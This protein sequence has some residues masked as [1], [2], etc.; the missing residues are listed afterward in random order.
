MSEAD[1]KAGDWRKGRAARTILDAGAIT[2]IV[3]VFELAADRWLSQTAIGMDWHYPLVFLAIMTYLLVRVFVF[4]SGDREIRR[5]YD[6]LARRR[7]LDALTR[8]PNRQ[9]MEHELEHMASMAKRMKCMLAVIILDVERLHEI[10]MAVGMSAGDETLLAVAERLKTSI[11]ESDALARIAGD[12]FAIAT[13]SCESPD[14]LVLFLNKLAQLFDKPLRIQSL[15]LDVEVRFGSILFPSQC[16]DPKA[17]LRKAYEALYHARENGERFG[18]YDSAFTEFGRWRIGLFGELKRAIEKEELQ[19][20]YQPQFALHSGRV[21]SAEALIR[22]VDKETGR[23]RS[24][25]EFVSLAE[26]T[27]LLR[28]FTELVVSQAVRQLSLWDDFPDFKVSVN[29]SAGILLDRSFSNFVKAQLMAHGVLAK[30][31]TLEVT[32]TMLML[33]T[34]RCLETLE[35]LKALGCEISLDD[36][37]TGYTSLSYLQDL[38][39]QELKVDRSFVIKLEEPKTCSIV[40]RVLEMSGDLDVRTVAEGIETH[41]Q[42]ERLRSLGCTLGQGFLVSPAIPASDFAERFLAGAGNGQESPQVPM[43]GS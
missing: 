25:A 19:L 16:P 12:Q 22:W 33:Q 23:V 35:Q 41:Q 21:V 5:L 34:S 27:H 26:K 15:D 20:F 8:L 11:R 10:N 2:L 37:G 9:S 30:R 1:N 38:P 42:M 39:V 4:H 36:F 28:P 7:F 31:L 3:V 13:V 18:F 14:H 24:P 32:E 29:L 43:A 40:R 17:L 6:A